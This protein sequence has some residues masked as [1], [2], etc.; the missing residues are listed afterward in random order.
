M[1][2]AATYKTKDFYFGR[3]LDYDFSYNNEI[4]IAPRNFQF[5]FKEMNSIKSHYAIIGMAFVV[6]DYPLYYDGINEKGLGIAGL[7]FVGNANYK[8]KVSDKDNIISSET[9]FTGDGRRERITLR[10]LNLFHGF[11]VNVLL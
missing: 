9:Q 6:D 8:E 3:N 1:C 10:S 2:T 7:N 5:D 4:T 11:Y